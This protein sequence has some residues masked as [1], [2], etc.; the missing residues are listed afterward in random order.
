M[1]INPAKAEIIELKHS[2]F[3]SHEFLSDPV[4]LQAKINFLQIENA[5]LQARLDT[6]LEENKA[7]K[8]QLNSPL[9]SSASLLPAKN[10]SVIQGIMTLNKGS[11]EGVKEGMVVVS[12]E[13]LVGKVISVTPY[14]SRIELPI[15]EGNKIKVKIVGINEKGILRGTPENRL[16]LEEVLQ[17]AELQE[18]QV[19]VTAGEE[20]SYPPDLPIGKIE[21]IIRDDVAVYKKAEV[22]PLLDYNNLKIVMVRI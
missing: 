14:A 5:S 18:D 12:D 11:Q 21:N 16:L 15:R 4:I 10:L 9:N 17:K 7:L 22:K 20:G 13:V 6:L 2:L 19:V 1:V 3:P 8:K